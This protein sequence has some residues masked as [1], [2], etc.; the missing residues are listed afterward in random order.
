MCVCL[1]DQKRRGGNK[2]GACAISEDGRGRSGENLTRN[3]GIDSDRI[4]PDKVFSRTR[5]LLQISS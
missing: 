5:G 2:P 1:E 3:C 4:S